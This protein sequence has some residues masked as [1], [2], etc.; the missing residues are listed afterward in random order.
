MIKN[1]DKKAV[2][3]RNIKELINAGYIDCSND[4]LMMIKANKIGLIYH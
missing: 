1:T 2:I 4:D 3:F